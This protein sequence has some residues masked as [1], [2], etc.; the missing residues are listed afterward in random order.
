VVNLFRQVALIVCITRN[1]E[2]IE[3]SIA[4]NEDEIEVIQSDILIN[5]CGSCGNKFDTETLIKL[6]SIT[7][8]GTTQISGN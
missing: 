2:Q 3:H 5:L 6:I 1:I 4:S 8:G 7:P